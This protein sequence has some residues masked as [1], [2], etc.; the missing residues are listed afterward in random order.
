MSKSLFEYASSEKSNNVE[1]KIET[2]SKT[3]NIS[4]ENL[5]KQYDKYSKLS[6][7]ELMSELFSEVNKQKMNGSFNFQDLANKIEGI[8]PMLSDQ[9]LKNLDNLLKQI[10]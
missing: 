9:Q 10:K 6:E 4:E 1:Q 3:E 2:K 8:R 5:K 7:R